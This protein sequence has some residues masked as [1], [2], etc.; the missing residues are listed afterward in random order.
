MGI[1]DEYVDG[2]L[3]LFLCDTSTKEDVYFHSVLRDMGYADICGENIPSQ[4]RRE[5]SAAERKGKDPCLGA[6]KWKES[7]L[8]ASGFVKSKTGIP[9][10]PVAFHFVTASQNV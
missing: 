5:A 3:Y 7:Y 8:E 1:V 2:V 10:F 9:C 6:C 4:V